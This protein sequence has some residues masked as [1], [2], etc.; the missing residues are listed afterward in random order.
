MNLFEEIAQA[1]KPITFSFETNENAVK[2]LSVKGSRMEKFEKKK[3]K[4]IKRNENKN[5]LI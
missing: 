2:V 4:R 5:F 1:T 3:R